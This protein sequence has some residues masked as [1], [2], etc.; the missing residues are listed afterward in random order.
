MKFC[1]QCVTNITHY[2]QYGGD[3][4]LKICEYCGKEL[5]Y[6]PGNKDSV[7]EVKNDKKN[8]PKYKKM[9]SDYSKGALA[10]LIWFGALN[11]IGT[12]FLSIGITSIF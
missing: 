12:L 7:A 10:C 4:L 11:V 6:N 9:K 8:D 5:A 3:N 1:K 2:L